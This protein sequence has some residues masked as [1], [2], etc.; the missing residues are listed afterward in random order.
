[1]LISYTI[2]SCSCTGIGR[3]IRACARVPPV[4]G[5]HVV[6]KL[7]PGKR[8]TRVAFSPAGKGAFQRRLQRPDRGPCRR[9]V[10][11]IS[12]F[13]YYYIDL[14]NLMIA[15]STG[16]A[17][18]VFL[19]HA[20]PALACPLDPHGPIRQLPNPTVHRPPKPLRCRSHQILSPR[21][22]THT[23]PRPY[24]SPSLPAPRDLAR[25]RQPPPS[26]P[27][28]PPSP[29]GAPRL[30]HTRLRAFALRP[31]STPLPRPPSPP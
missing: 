12:L 23:P 20:G 25:R 26:T 29:P 24:P 9:Q 13:L 7:L 8:V 4:S 6:V 18:T 2:I 27:A 31:H 17:L 21:S 28:R 19:L 1:M 30:L 22:P 16:P 3:W 5:R 15:Y 11:I 10:R 14:S